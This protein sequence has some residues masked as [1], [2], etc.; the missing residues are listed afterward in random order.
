M[1]SPTH[2]RGIVVVT[3]APPGGLRRRTRCAPAIG[4]LLAARWPGGCGQ[5]VKRSA[6]ASNASPTQAST[7]R[8]T[9]S[10]ESSA[11]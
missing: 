7:A 11:R 5:S 1:H 2:G 9:P 6:S 10:N 3:G 8:L 4:W